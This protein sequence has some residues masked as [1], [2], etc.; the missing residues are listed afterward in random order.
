VYHYKKDYYNKRQ[1]CFHLLI[2]TKEAKSTLK[3]IIMRHTALVLFSLLTFIMLA[4]TGAFLFLKLKLHPLLV[5]GIALNIA[6]F[7]LYAIDKLFA[8]IGFIRVPES[9]LHLLT[10]LGATPA[11]LLGQ[12]LLRHKTIK[13]RFRKQFSIIVGFQLLLLVVYGGLI[14][15]WA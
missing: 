14:I 5:Y 12:K 4:V 10:L 15:Y 1:C 11:A 9:L 7:I 8:K 2:V 6:L 3:V 13:E